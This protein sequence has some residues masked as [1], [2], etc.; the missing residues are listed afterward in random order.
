V[1]TSEGFGEYTHHVVPHVYTI[2]AGFCKPHQ[3][4]VGT[5]KPAGARA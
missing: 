4:V 5:K 3:D 1:Y 2:V